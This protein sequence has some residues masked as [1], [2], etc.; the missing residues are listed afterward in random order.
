MEMCEVKPSVFQ[1]LC[2]VDVTSMLQY[3][4]A[5]IRPVLPCLTRMLLCSSVDESASWQESRKDLMRLL[6]GI[7]DVNDIVALLSVDFPS[8]EAA[9]KIERQ[10]R[11]KVHNDGSIL[12]SL[13]QKHG[14]LLEFERSEPA[15]KLQILLSEIMPLIDAFSNLANDDRRLPNLDGQ[16]Y[17][18]NSELFSCPSYLEVVSDV[19]CIAAMELPSLMNMVNLAE[20]LIYVPNGVKVLCKLVANCSSSILPVCRALIKNHDS[21]FHAQSRD[22]LKCIEQR[23]VYAVETLCSLKPDIAMNVRSMTVH[24]CKLPGLA[25]SLVLKNVKTP[26]NENTGCVSELVAFVSGLLLGSKPRIRSWF[27]LYIKTNQ[28]VQPNRLRKELE[29]ELQS[30]AVSTEQEVHRSQPTMDDDPVLHNMCLL[31]EEECLRATTLIR[32]C[33]ALKA[34]AGLKFSQVETDLVLRL[35]TCFPPLTASGIRFMSLSLS[36][37][38]A[39]SALISGPEKETRSINWIKWLASRSSELQ[40]AGPEGGSFAEQL[41]LMAIHLHSDQRNAVVQLACSTLGMRIKVPAA[42]LTR[43]RLSL[44]HI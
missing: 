13:P 10:M 6:S 17:A 5:E 26:C 2:S 27:A 3:T 25:V 16:G 29:K 42:S 43:M 31:S 34:I 39:C 9:A 18:T 8:L 28:E 33:C 24:Y 1:S 23:R 15:R 32:L 44:I 41:L 14:I 35:I 40:N 21:S 38:L 4:V 37:L 7:E 11:L 20:T 36:M 22:V 30:I 19:F 12:T